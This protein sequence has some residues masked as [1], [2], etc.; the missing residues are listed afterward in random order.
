MIQKRR[1]TVEDDYIHIIAPQQRDEFSRQLGRVAERG[2]RQPVRVDVDRHV[3]IA[4]RLRNSEGL[5]AKEIGFENLRPRQEIPFQGLDESLTTCRHAGIIDPN[6]PAEQQPSIRGD[7]A[8]SFE[9]ELTRP[10]HP[11]LARREAR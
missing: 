8:R 2:V 10:R 1:G 11:N 5:G 3:D 9:L 7:R 4:V 6:R